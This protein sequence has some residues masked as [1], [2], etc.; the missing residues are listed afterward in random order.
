MRV[1]AAS[2]R[3]ARKANRGAS[4]SSQRSTI[5]LAALTRARLR[6]R[7]NDPDLVIN[8]ALDALEREEY[9]AQALRDALLLAGDARDR[10][11]I[12]QLH[13][14]LTVPLELLE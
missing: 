1:G 13:R 11:E 8:A 6:A 9:A 3:S 4:P 2:R 14:E 10:E 7:G 5:G 12:Q